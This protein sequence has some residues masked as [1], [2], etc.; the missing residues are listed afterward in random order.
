VNVFPETLRPLVAEYANIK[1]KGSTGATNITAAPWIALFDRRLTTTATEEYYVVYL[2]STDISTVTLCLA[3]GTT[4]FEKQFGGPSKSFPRMRAATVRLQ[5]AFRHLIPAYLKQGSID[6]AAEPGQ[7]LHYAYQQSAILSY[8]PY[9]IDALPEE[10][11]LVN[12]LQAL[13]HLYTEIVS[14]PLEA[15]V[16][17]LLEAVVNP[18]TKVEAIEVRDFK[19]RPRRKIR[20]SSSFTGQARR[21]SPVSRKVGDAGERV[22]MRYERERLLKIGRQDLADR[23]RWHA[24]ELEFPGWDITSFDDNGNMC[25]IEVKSSIGKAVSGITVTVNEWQAACD[26]RWRDRYFIYIVSD[27]LSAAPKIERLRNPASRVDE[28]QLSCEPIVYELQL[29]PP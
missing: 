19:T 4:Q 7:R 26:S 24:Q 22:V 2:F 29:S 15:T 13:V 18:A 9:R 12:D 3:F 10:S 25:F 11:Q 1:V 23:V 27:A 20:D 8:P 17:R 14:D 5:E 6:L 16:E 28:R 21:Y